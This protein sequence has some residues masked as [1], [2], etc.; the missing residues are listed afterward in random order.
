MAYQLTQATFPLYRH[1]KSKKTFTQPQLAACVLLMFYVDQSYRDFEEWLAASDQVCAALG[2]S[3]IPD[4]STLNRAVQRLTVI[5]LT[6]LLTAGLDGGIILISAPAGFGKTCLIGEWITLYKISAAWLSLDEEDNDL[7]RFLTYLVAALHGAQE[8]VGLAPLALLR[9]PRPAPTRVVLTSLLND[10][11]GLPDDLILAVQDGEIV[12]GAFILDAEEIWVD[13]L[14]VRREPDL[15]R[16][17]ERRS[18]R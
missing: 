8:S 15:A 14:A 9:P 7:V 11:S 1:R 2:L 16:L 12:G 18:G 6:R 10:L 17:P 5:R 4:H 3:T 13:K